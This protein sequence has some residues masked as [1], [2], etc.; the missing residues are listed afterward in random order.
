MTAYSEDAALS[1]LEAWSAMTKDVHRCKREDS[2]EQAEK[3]MAEQQVSR[4]PVV[5][6]DDKPVG[7]LSIHDLARHAASSGQSQREVLETMAAIVAR[8]HEA[9]SNA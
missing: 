4:I 8:K 2:I 1:S 7:L 6:S 3:L 5:D 9:L